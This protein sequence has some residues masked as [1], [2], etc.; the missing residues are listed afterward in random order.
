[1][2]IYSTIIH[3]IGYGLAVVSVILLV[4]CIG[5]LCDEI[6][7]QRRVHNMRQM[8]RDELDIIDTSRPLKQDGQ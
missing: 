4:A 8:I 7:T 6:S 5:R 2:E 1:M 3:I